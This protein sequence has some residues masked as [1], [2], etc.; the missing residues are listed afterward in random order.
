MR[1]GSLIK[2]ITQLL[3]LGSINF[4][5][6]YG[7]EAS[8]DARPGANVRERT[9]LHSGWKF[10]NS[11]TTP[12]GVTYSLRP[13]NAS[14]DLEELRD[15]V[16]PVAN[17]FIADADQHYKRPASE[18]KVVI[19]YV[20]DGFDDGNWTSVTVPHDWAIT[21][22]FV[23]PSEVAGDMGSLPVRGVNG[24]SHGR[25]KTEPLTYLFRWDDV[26]YEPG[27]VKVIVYKDGKRWS[28][29]PVVTTGKAAALRLSADRTTITADGE[30]LTFSTA[31]HRQQGQCGTNGE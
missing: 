27:E 14:E 18:P 1:F 23:G 12:D 21:G 22:D 10:L 5:G 11:P 3:L 4:H 13:D 20:A 25:Q 19:E 31:G 8:P 9:R 6:N 17:E 24:K 7:V 26:I 30:D 15:W 28:T 2:D 16:L 29:D